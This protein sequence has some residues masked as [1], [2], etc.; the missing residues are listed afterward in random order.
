MVFWPHLDHVE[1]GNAVFLH[2]HGHGDAVFLDQHGES[3]WW[4]KGESGRRLT[5]ERGREGADGKEG[6]KGQGRLEAYYMW[7]VKSPA[8]VHIDDFCWGKDKIKALRMHVVNKFE[9]KYLQ[10]VVSSHSRHAVQPDDGCEK[11]FQTTPT[12]LERP[13][14][15]ETSLNQQ[16]KHSSQAKYNSMHTNIRSCKIPLHMT[17]DNES[18][19][20][21]THSWRGWESRSHL[22]HMRSI[23]LT[24]VPSKS[25]LYG[26]ASA[27]FLHPALQIQVKHFLG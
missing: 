27:L 14:K 25:C 5:R 15:A 10:L 26:Q 1:L 4:E 19:S 18:S 12:S 20:W 11:M 6:E 22:R 13:S 17:E 24:Y 7:L 21:L 16:H 8:E 23:L 9:N 2:T 3:R